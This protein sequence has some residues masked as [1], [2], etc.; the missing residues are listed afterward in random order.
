MRYILGTL[1]LTLAL[2]TGNASASTPQAEQRT[3]AQSAVPRCI[4]VD[5]LRN[6]VRVP[7]HGLYRYRDM[8]DYLQF[9][10]GTPRPLVRAM[11][12]TIY[13]L[14]DSLSSPRPIYGWTCRVVHT[15]G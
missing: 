9:P 2:F 6:T 5:T 1:F 3:G 10:A 11:S 15:R 12:H 7:G 14:A 13:R 8:G 4:H